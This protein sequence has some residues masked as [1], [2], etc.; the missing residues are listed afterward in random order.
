MGGEG[1]KHFFRK[2]EKEPTSRRICRAFHVQGTKSEQIQRWEGACHVI[3]A[4]N[5]PY[6][7]LEP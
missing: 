4:I 1:K 3:R 7:L 6:M 2:M 5:V